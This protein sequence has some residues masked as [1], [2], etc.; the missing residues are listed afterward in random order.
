MTITAPPVAILDTKEDGFELSGIDV[1]PKQALVMTIGMPKLSAAATATVHACSP[2][3]PDRVS[4]LRGKPVP[5][6]TATQLDGKSLRLATY[7][8]KLIAV[9]FS[10]SWNG[11]ARPEYPAFATLAGKLPDIAVVEVMSDADP[12]EVTAVIG[13]ASASHVVLD[14]PGTGNL[15][16][17]T[18]AWGLNAVPETF[19]ID[20]HGIVRYHFTNV[21]DWASADAIACIKALARE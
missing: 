5:D 1:V 19:L 17:I 15:G 14:P 20:R 13:A 8:G 6:F 12:H 9:S 2:L 16:P 3:A 10:A 21:R 7:K 4:A 18:T 11:F